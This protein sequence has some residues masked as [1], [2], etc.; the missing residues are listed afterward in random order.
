V[1][2]DYRPLPLPGKAGLLSE[3]R[4]ILKEGN[5]FWAI[6]RGGTFADKRKL[7]VSELPRE[8]AQLVQ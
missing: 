1:C 5:D 3:S 4:V 2:I 8:V 7:E 6:E